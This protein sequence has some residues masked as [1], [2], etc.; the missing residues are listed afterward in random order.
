M[1]R[2]KALLET[3]VEST[4]QCSPEHKLSTSQSLLWQAGDVDLL[5]CRCAY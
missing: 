5:Y 1:G 3:F 2:K 4:Q